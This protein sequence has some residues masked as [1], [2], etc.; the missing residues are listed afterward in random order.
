MKGIMSDQRC[1]DSLTYVSPVIFT[2]SLCFTIFFFVMQGE[3]AIKGR[4][5]QYTKAWTLPFSANEM[6]FAKLRLKAGLDLINFRTFVRIGFRTEQVEFRDISTLLFS[7]TVR[8]EQDVSLQLSSLTQWCSA[9]ELQSRT[10]KILAL[11]LSYMLR[12]TFAYMFSVHAVASCQATAEGGS[13]IDGFPLQT[14]WN[15]PISN[16]SNVD[17]PLKLQV[18]S[19]PAQISY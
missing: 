16:A 1:S 10:L 17:P 19:M 5:L 4:E 7:C 15:V 3:L 6:L 11:G 18:C 8:V 2:N 12:Y 14:T 9:T 13:L